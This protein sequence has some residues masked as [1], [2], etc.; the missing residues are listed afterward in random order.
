MAQRLFCDANAGQAE[1]QFLYSDGV[2]NVPI[3]LL[4]FG[5]PGV[6]AFPADAPQYAPKRH[7]F[8]GEIRP[9]DEERLNAPPTQSISPYF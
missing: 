1:F 2:E 4:F 7:V 8:A 5:V 3:A 9:R 6:G